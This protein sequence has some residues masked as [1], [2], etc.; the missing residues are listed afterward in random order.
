MFKFSEGCLITFDSLY[1]KSICNLSF[2]PGE[3]E[4]LLCPG[5]ILWKDYQFKDGQHQFKASVIEPLEKEATYAPY[6]LSC[7][8]TLVNW[9]KQ[10]GIDCDFL[11]PEAKLL[12]Q[13]D[14]NPL[15]LDDCFLADTSPFLTAY[16][17]PPTGVLPDLP[18]VLD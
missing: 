18:L 17:L 6:E 5:K 9:A 11:T 12:C 8:K 16:Q 10:Q 3:Q 1:G 14:V 13:T 7:F 4:F 15:T 2:F